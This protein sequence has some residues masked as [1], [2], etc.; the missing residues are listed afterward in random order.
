M[1]EDNIPTVVAL[2]FTEIDSALFDQKAPLE[3]HAQSGKTSHTVLLPNNFF[4]C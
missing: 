2:D 4:D 3:F 1:H